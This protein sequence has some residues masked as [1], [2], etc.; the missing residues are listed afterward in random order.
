MSLPPRLATGIPG[1]DEMLQGGFLPRTANL[2]E[3]APGTG[4][5]TFGLQFI[6]HGIVAW[7]QPGLILTFEEFPKQYYRDA[8]GFGWDLP[9]LEKDNKLRVVMTSPEVTL[10]DLQRV[11]GHLENYAREI[12]AQRVLIDSISHFE[13][14]T[15]DPVKLRSVV[16]QFINSLKRIGL[17]AI[18][19]RE[20]PALL[21]ETPEVEEDLAFVADSYIMLRFVEIESALAK[22][23]LVLKQRSSNHARD[24]RQYEITASGL[25]VRGPFEGAQGVMSG[26]PVM[27]MRDAFQTICCMYYLLRDNRFVEIGVSWGFRA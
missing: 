21:G 12:E 14:I 11:G 24:I 23:L 9:A 13:R 26:S 5:S 7:N 2:V 6:Y 19:T 16:Y 4:K 22:A 8:L 25:V 1:L 17:T 15:T 18:L 20:N 27:T 3:G 10:H